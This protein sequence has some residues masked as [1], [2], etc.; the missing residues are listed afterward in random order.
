M[1]D[2]PALVSPGLLV[3]NPPYGERLGEARISRRYADLG[4]MIKSISLVESSCFYG[5]PDLG[6][7]LSLRAVL[8]NK[9]NNGLLNVVCSDLR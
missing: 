5:R 9:F 3:T 8:V 2:T 4:S 7:Y 1:R 6:R